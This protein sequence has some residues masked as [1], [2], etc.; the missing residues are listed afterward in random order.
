[1][2]IYLTLSTKSVLGMAKKFQ[3]LLQNFVI[4]HTS[5]FPVCYAIRCYSLLW[6]Q[7]LIPTIM[8]YISPSDYS[9]IKGHM[10]KA[11]HNLPIAL[12]AHLTH[13]TTWPH[14]C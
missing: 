5:G 12:T 4:W 7:Q 14:H 2:D 10:Y 9:I 13:L 1:V 3:T 11:S 8:R 6:L